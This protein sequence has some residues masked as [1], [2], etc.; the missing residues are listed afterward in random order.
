[1]GEFMGGRVLRLVGGAALLG[2]LVV[3]CGVEQAAPDEVDPGSGRTHAVDE[4]RG[5]TDEDREREPE[6]NVVDDEVILVVDDEADVHEDCEHRKVVVSA[7]NAKVVLDGECGL[8]RASGR[9]SV[10]EV[11]SAEKIVLV[12]VDNKVSFAGGDPVVVNHGRNTTVT[13]GG[14]AGI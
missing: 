8:V 13:E 10:V 5:S 11:G 4:G 6:G 14:D 2:S 12:G 9:G 3:G 1:M 7:D